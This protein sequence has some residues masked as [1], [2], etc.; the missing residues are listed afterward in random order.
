MFADLDESLRQLLV[1]RGNLDHGEVDIAFDM[2]TRD[3]A[4]GISKPTVNLDLFVKTPR[5]PGA[6]WG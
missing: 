5:Q 2:P 6:R 3:W 4:S 1:Q